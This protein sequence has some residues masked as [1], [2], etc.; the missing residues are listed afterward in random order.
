MQKVLGIDGS[1]E[2]LNDVT[3][4]GAQ[5]LVVKS[6]QVVSLV[7]VKNAL[8]RELRGVEGLTVMPE[9]SPV[10]AS[11][12]N[13]VI[14]W[15]MQSTT[16]AIVAYLS[17]CMKPY[18]NQAVLFW[19]GLWSSKDRLSGSKDPFRMGRQRM[20]GGSRTDTAKRLFLSVKW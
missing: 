11:A 13:A 12:A 1:L 8:V 3:M 9:E 10:G 6:D 15:E 4:S 16:R 5:T 2:S 19:H 14:E 20:N 18:L 17:G 7:G